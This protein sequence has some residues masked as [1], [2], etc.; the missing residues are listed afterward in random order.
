MRDAS[1]AVL[2]LHGFPQTH[3]MW[4]RVAVQLRPHYRLVPPDLRGY[5]DSGKP[6]SDAGVKVA[7][8]VPAVPPPDAAPA[9]PAQVTVEDLRKLYVSVGGAVD[10]LERQQ[11]A[12]TTRPY[13]DR[14]LRIPFSDALRTPALRRD[15]E[16]TLKKLRSDIGKLLD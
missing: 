5:G 9:A 1:A 10:K 14:Y 4:H 7:Q 11:G 12:A 16:G 6:P 8:P 3:A 15:V 2:L 13:R